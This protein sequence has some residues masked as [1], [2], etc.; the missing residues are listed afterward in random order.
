MGS[1]QNSPSSKIVNS[2]PLQKQSSTTLTIN[3]SVTW[4]SEQSFPIHNSGSNTITTT[5]HLSPVRVAPLKARGQALYTFWV[6]LR[7]NGAASHLRFQPARNPQSG[8]PPRRST[9]RSHSRNSNLHCL[10]ITQ[11][12]TIR[13]SSI[14]ATSPRL[15]GPACSGR[16]RTKGGGKSSQTVKFA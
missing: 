6:H 3:L 8:L 5:T 14:S 9:T 7:A 2:T 10:T 15:V 11:G 12:L 13:E 4:C 16:C 1:I